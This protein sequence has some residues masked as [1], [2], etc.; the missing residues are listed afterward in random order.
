MVLDRGVGGGVQAD[1]VPGDQVAVARPG[2]DLH[3]VG[4][5]ARDQVA[6]PG[7]RP[8]DGVAACP[9]FDHHAVGIAHGGRDAG[10]DAG[11]HER[12]VARRVRFTHKV[13]LAV[14]QHGHV[15]QLFLPAPEVQFHLAVGAEGGIDA[16]VAVELRQPEVIDDRGFVDVL[17]DQQLAA[18]CQG[19]PNRIASRQ[20]DDAV[21]AEGIVEGAV[22]RV[23]RHDAAVGRAVVGISTQHNR[24]VGLDRDSGAH[25][26]HAAAEV[27]N[28]DTGLSKRRVEE[29]VGG[30]AG[31]GDRAGT[32]AVGVADRDQVAVRL[33][34]EGFDHGPAVAYLRRDPARAVGAE[35]GVDAAVGID[36]HEGEFSGVPNAGHDDLAVR[37]KEVGKGLLAAVGAA[38]RDEVRDDDP[39][40]RAEAGIQRPGGRVV[41]GERHVRDA[42]D[43][44]RRGTNQHDLAVGLQESRVSDVAGLAPANGRPEVRLNV[45][46]DAEAGIE[47][48]VG[49]VLHHLEVAGPVGTVTHDDH[50]PVGQWHY[51]RGIVVVR[52]RDVGD[53]VAG[54]V[55]A[56]VE[57]AAP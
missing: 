39:P 41:A 42:I 18:R 55:E 29:A 12:F 30:V 46:V 34:A 57:S 32:R 54:A 11:G 2:G 44:V 28:H 33:H 17:A 10:A 23:A 35:A 27:G 37:L 15:E 4:E 45:A 48:A 47:R 36:A 38:G 43:P 52:M 6:G 9:A 40:A 22:S 19:D 56:G 51:G 53:D 24:I 50:R 1:D 3:P 20:G 31:Q 25:A 5:I 7:D 49:F 8:A 13:N 14:G 16:A 26:T 21:R